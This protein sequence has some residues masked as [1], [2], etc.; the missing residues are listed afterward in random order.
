MWN[1]PEAARRKPKI[2]RLLNPNFE[3]SCRRSRISS[4]PPRLETSKASH[5]TGRAGIA[6]ICHGAPI[7]G[8]HLRNRRKSAGSRIGPQ[9]ENDSSSE[10]NRVW[11]LSRIAGLTP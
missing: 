8:E 7:G 10:M 11:R 5:E 6:D 1:W 2:G 3:S 4:S 9:K